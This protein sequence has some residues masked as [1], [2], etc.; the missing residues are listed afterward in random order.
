MHIH[1]WSE[2]LAG[3]RLYGV[4]V[5]LVPTFMFYVAKTGL[6]GAF[7]ARLQFQYPGKSVGFVFVSESAGVVRPAGQ[8]LR[9]PVW[10][11]SCPL[12][13]DASDRSV[14][15]HFTGEIHSER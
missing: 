10:E 14:F 5:Q 12:P 4:Y 3:G 8:K 2:G 9:E 13:D 1:A 7:R 11:A 6:K 15:A